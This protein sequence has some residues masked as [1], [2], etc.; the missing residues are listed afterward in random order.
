LTFGGGCEGCGWPGQENGGWDIQNLRLRGRA[1]EN[2]AQT[3]RALVYL[4][5]LQAPSFARRKS[6][7]D[8][9]LRRFR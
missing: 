4:I 6:T 2:P 1:K 9:G 7:A 3:P 8:G 5:T